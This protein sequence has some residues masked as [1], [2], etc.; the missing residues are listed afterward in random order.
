MNIRQIAKIAG[1]F[2]CLFT[3]YD[4]MLNY[5]ARVYQIIFEIVSGL[6]RNVTAGQSRNGG[7]ACSND[8]V[9]RR[10]VLL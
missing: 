8:P 6:A 1:F 3:Y 10:P 2:I 4:R 5:A 9:A 7:R